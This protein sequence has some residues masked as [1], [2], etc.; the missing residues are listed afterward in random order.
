MAKDYYEILGVSKGSSAD[1]IKKAYRKAAVQFHPDKAKGEEQKKEFDT[2][3]KEINKAYDVLKDPQKKAAYDSYGHAAFEQGAGAGGFG[4]GNPFGGAGGFGGFDFGAGAGGFA[5]EDI[6]DMF[7]GRQGAGRGGRRAD[8]RGRDLHYAINISF[9]MSVHGGQEKVQL[10]HMANCHTC[11]GSGSAKDSKPETC[12]RCG[13]SGQVSQTTNSVFGQFAT[14]TACPK[15]HG[16]GTIIKK[17]C[18][19]CEGS[20]RE[21]ETEELTITVP[22]GVDSGTELRFAGRGDVGLRGAPAG[23]LYLEFRVKPHKYFKRRGNDIFLDLP[24]TISQAALGDT[25]EVPT[26]DGNSKVKV[27]S[28]VTNGTQIKVASKGVQRLGGNG[29]GDQ[30]LTVLLQMPTK[31]S[32]EEKKLLEQL[33]KV[34][35]KPKLPWN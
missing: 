10:T 30:Y 34:E 20:G 19:T 2:K 23:D 13:G 6:F 15:C 8:T 18:P 11:K 21:K 9:E 3:F 14:V 17:P 22:A 33:A 1:D 4:G 26:I 29:R 16:E 24:L 25:I 7:F 35:N 5:S 32:G 28:G 12:D 27:P 31:P